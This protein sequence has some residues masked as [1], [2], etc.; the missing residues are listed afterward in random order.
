MT[1]ITLRKTLL[2]ALVSATASG[3]FAAVP[4]QC[5]T[6][7]MTD[8]GWTDI[9][10]TNGLATTVLEALGYQTDIKLLA[11][12]I[13]YESIKN[14]Q[15]DVFLGNWMPAQSTFIE[16]YADDLD[17]IRT[18]LTGVK[19]TLAVPAYMY[20]KGVQDFKDLHKYA[21]DFG[22]RIYG[23][24]AGSPANQNL[25]NMIDKNDFNLGDWRV[26]ESG[27]QAMLA[28]VSRAVKREKGIVFLAW[29]PHPMNVNFDLKYLS[30]GDDYF[31][32]NYGGATIHTVT[33]KGYA[34]ECGNVAKLLQNMEFTLDMENTV[35]AMTSDGMSANEAASTWLKSNPAVLDTWLDGVTTTSGQPGINA[36]K[37]ALDL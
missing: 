36:V 27:E 34:S 12:P 6:V 5:Q 1:Q 31:G 35:I 9:G 11:V 21:R 37:S 23:I 13:G 2:A 8:P 3:A 20:D 16:K 18:N 25:M 24:G 32:P 10:A 26:V 7:T 17:V 22:E 29:E 19:F 33:R 15:I 30:G 28:Q 4:E 14:N